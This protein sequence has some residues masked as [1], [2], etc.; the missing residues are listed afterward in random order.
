MRKSLLSL[1]CDIATKMVF[2]AVNFAGGYPSHFCFSVSLH[3][4]SG[5]TFQN[6]QCTMN[7][8]KVLNQNKKYLV[9]PDMSATIPRAVT[10]MRYILPLREGL[11]LPGL[12]EA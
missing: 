1:F 7:S 10:V 12:A 3:Y 2:F 6:S 4:L 11:S 9:L 8:V 5:G